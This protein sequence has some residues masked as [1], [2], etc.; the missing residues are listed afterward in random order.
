M[1]EKEAVKKGFFN[2]V[3][4]KKY[5]YIDFLEPLLGLPLAYSALRILEGQFN[6]VTYVLIFVL[7]LIYLPTVVVFLESKRF[8]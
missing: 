8:S 1:D 5:R 2:Y 3:L 7:L 6:L 4:H